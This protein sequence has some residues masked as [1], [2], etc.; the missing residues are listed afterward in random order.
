MDSNRAWKY[1]RKIK[2]ALHLHKLSP[3]VRRIVVGMV[4]SVV[5]LVGAAMVFLPGPAF[6]MIPLGLAILATEFP[7]ARTWLHKASS[8][9]KQGRERFR[10]RRA[11]QRSG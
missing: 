11:A 2:R 7:W 9:F 3:G 1:L 6:V 4:G 5:L 8:L 10:R